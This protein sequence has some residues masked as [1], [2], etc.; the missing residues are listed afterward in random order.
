MGCMLD[1]DWSRKFLLRCDWL[2]LP[3]ASITTNAVQHFFF[4]KDRRG[5]VTLF[6]LKDAK[7]IRAGALSIKCNMTVFFD[8]APRRLVSCDLY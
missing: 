8:R 5:A 2:G 4:L 6:D 3:V 7:V 1:S